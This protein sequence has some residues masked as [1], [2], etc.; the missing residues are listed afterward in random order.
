MCTFA[1][2]SVFTQFNHQMTNTVMLC[3][4]SLLFIL[5]EGLLRWFAREIE[6]CP[7]SDVCCTSSLALTSLHFLCDYLQS[8][9]IAHSFESGLQLQLNIWNMPDKVTELSD[10]GLKVHEFKDPL[11]FCI[12]S[13]MK[14]THNFDFIVWWM[15]PIQYMDEMI[16]WT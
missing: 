11:P 9:M 10:T 4:D 12:F 7:A 6:N 14:P 13:C 15:D 16:D 5:K 2:G 8:A 1:T 3:L